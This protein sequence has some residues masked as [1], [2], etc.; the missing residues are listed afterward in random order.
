MQLQAATMRFSASWMVSRL[1]LLQWFTWLVQMATQS[2]AW[3]IFPPPADDGGYNELDAVRLL[4][5]RL[6]QLDGLEGFF[7]DI[8]RGI[9]WGGEDYDHDTPINDGDDGDG[10]PECDAV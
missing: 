7:D 8:G 2:A 6:H 1:R 3:L 4:G 9:E 5:R 10:E